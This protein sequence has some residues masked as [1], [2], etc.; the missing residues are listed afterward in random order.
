MS[1]SGPGN[2]PT[3]PGPPGSP[4]QS[5]GPRPMMIRPQQM[6]VGSSSPPPPLLQ[7]FDIIYYSSF[8]YFYLNF[9]HIFSIRILI[10]KCRTVVT[11]RINESTATVSKYFNI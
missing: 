4:L 8:K 3:P 9:E 2:G 10:L 1:G 5:P 6:Q 11:F 7:H